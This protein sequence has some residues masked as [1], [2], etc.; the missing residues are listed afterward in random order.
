MRLVKMRHP[1]VQDEI[2]VLEVAVGQHAN[3][4]WQTVEELQSNAVAA[5]EM[6]AAQVLEQVGSDSVKARAAL[7]V[8]RAGK[9]RVT[10]LRDLER[11]AADQTADSA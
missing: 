3:A 1:D 6:T 11:L 2:E 9:Q 8:E 4:G 7:D 10:L 5:D